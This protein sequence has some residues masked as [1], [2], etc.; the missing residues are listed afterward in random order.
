MMIKQSALI[1]V[2]LQND[3]SPGGIMSVPQSHD[4]VPIVNQLQ[5][6]FPLIIATQD[7]HPQDH[8]SFAS[9]HPGHRVHDVIEV[10][11]LPQTLWYDH[12]VQGTEG[13]KLHPHLVTSH[14]NKIFLKG[15][16]SHIDSYSAFYDNAHLRST[17]L[18][19]YLR[20]QGIKHVYLVGILIDYCVMYSALDAVRDGFKVSVIMDACWGLD[21]QPGDVAKAVA[22]M[23]KVDVEMMTS[24]TLL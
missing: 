12:C 24:N 21:A 5:E 2:D 14:L 20:E 15:T 16:E 3:F 11:G 22:A 23:Q 18:T 7:W 6:R 1:I 19:D 17:G 13:A 8:V 10:H 4:I 9:N